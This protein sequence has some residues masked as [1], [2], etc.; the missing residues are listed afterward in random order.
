MIAAGPFI[1]AAIG[2]N[3]AGGVVSALELGRLYRVF[4]D[5]GLLSWQVWRLRRRRAVQPVLRLGGS[6]FAWPGIMG[7]LSVRIASALACLVCA[8]LG[9]VPV[10]LLATYVA[11]GYL[12]MLRTPRAADGAAQFMHITAVA[13]LVTVISSGSLAGE[14]GLFFLSAQ[15]SLAYAVS[16]I[17]KIVSPGWRSGR[18]LAEIFATGTLGRQSVHEFLTSR[19]QRAKWASRVVISGELLCSLAPWSPPRMA[20]LL[21]AGAASFHVAAAAVMG[22]NMFTF[23]FGAAFPAAIYTSLILYR[24]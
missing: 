16:A 3:A 15:L 1:R 5:A 22:L 7:L 23:A 10:P 9:P 8:S 20:W 12:L 24:G 21:L 19:P 4:Q 13:C 6:I 18:F 14:M 11:T 2:I 17:V